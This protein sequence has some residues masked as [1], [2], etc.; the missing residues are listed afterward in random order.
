MEKD[1]LISHSGE[2]PTIEETTLEDS[3]VLDENVPGYSKENNIATYDSYENI[4]SI[5]NTNVG[6]TNLEEKLKEMIRQ[7]ED[8]VLTNSGSPTESQ[9]TDNTT[10]GNSVNNNIESTADKDNLVCHLK[11]LYFQYRNFISILNYPSDCF[12]IYKVPL[13]CTLE[14]YDL[15][16]SVSYISVIHIII[17]INLLSPF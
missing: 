1:N 16:K 9:E 14:A 4:T 17:I 11:D 13:L 6:D 3:V 7:N 2:S 15:Y 8:L 10:D 5:L 12:I